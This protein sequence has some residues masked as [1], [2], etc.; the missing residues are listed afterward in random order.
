LFVSYFKLGL[1]SGLMLFSLAAAVGIT[2]MYVGAH[3][4]RDVLG[5]AILGLVWGIVTGIIVG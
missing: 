3:Y 5:G 1:G 2:R 4:P